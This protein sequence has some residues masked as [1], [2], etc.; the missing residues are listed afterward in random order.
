[1]VNGGFE[2]KQE[3]S[4][5]KTDEET[6]KSKE[7]ALDLQKTFT[8]GDVQVNLD[9]Q[10]ILAEEKPEV[11]VHYSVKDAEQV[12]HGPPKQSHGSY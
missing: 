10:Q 4:D 9:K 7:I 11:L 5:V 3:F 2:Q 12:A 8:N 1:M 6:I